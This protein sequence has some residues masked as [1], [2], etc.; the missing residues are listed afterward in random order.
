ML[1]AR[2]RYSSGRVVAL[3]IPLPWN[4]AIVARVALLR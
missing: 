4:V 2:P 1:S 3:M